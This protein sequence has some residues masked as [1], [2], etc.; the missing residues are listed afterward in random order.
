MAW[1]KKDGSSNLPSKKNMKILLI[2]NSFSIDSAHFLFD[3]AK[4]AGVN[5]VVGIAH[6]SG[7]SLEQHWD[8]IQNDSPITMYHKWSQSNGHTEQP[9]PLLK[10]IISDEKWDIITY[11]QASPDSGKYNTFQPYL[12]NIHGWVKGRVTNDNVR[13][14][15]NMT[16]PYATGATSIYGTQ[17]DMYEAIVDAYQQ[18]MEEMEF[19]IL[20]P[21]GTAVQNARNIE[22]LQVVGNDLCRDSRH[23][24]YGVARNIT[25]LTVF[26][27]LFSAYYNVDVTQNVTFVPDETDS[28]VYRAY[29]SRLAAKQATINPFKLTEI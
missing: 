2:G 28:T 6:G 21:V 13:Y 14:G 1:M 15:L 10:N 20:I 25:A 11:Q 27:T 22:H 3:V 4:S 5:L 17:M 18:A 9:N 19:D 29:L 23:L 8:A 7:Y 16:W 24:D 12:N 26:Q